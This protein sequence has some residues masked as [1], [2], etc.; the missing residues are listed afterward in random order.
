MTHI[1]MLEVDDDGQPR[2]LGRA[3]HR[4]RVRGG[5]SD[6]LRGTTL[7]DG[8]RRA[9]YRAMNDREV[10]KFQITF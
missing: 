8:R 9:G 3:R 7:C 2:D 6:R 4:R 5:A 1:A 10:L